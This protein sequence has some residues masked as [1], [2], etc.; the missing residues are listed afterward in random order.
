MSKDN[1]TVDNIISYIRTAIV[2]DVYPIGAKLPPEA[3]LMQT[4][5]VSRSS[6]REAIK[7][8]CTMGMLEIQRGRGT[9]VIAKEK[10]MQ[11]EA[12]LASVP[13]TLNELVDFCELVE[14]GTIELLFRNCGN[15]DIEE[16]ARWNERMREYLGVSLEAQELLEFDIAFRLEIASRC[17]NSLMHEMCRTALDMLRPFMLAEYK[18]T[19]FM[20]FVIYARHQ[21]IV[22][23]LRYRDVQMAKRIIR[24]G[25]K[26]FILHQPT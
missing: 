17:G 14:V 12:P 11:T 19:P 6:I 23:S 13:H 15:K 25:N 7:V 16:L 2:S 5:N 9:F 8:L 10:E 3:D 24:D 4:Y 18:S 1:S 21:Q 22:D 26:Q 20:D